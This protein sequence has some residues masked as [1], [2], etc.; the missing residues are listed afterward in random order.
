MCAG[1]SIR[2]QGDTARRAGTDAAA[3]TKLERVTPSMPSN[4]RHPA[5]RHVA[6]WRT[7][8]YLNRALMARRCEQTPEDARNG[9]SKGGNG[10]KAPRVRRVA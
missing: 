8:S 2:W 1:G 10:R 9:G 5:Q 3:V 7:K 4:D 6:S